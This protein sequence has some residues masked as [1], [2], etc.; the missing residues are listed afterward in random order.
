MT[1]QLL[2]KQ[3]IEYVTRNA[4]DNEDVRQFK[5]RLQEAIF[6]AEHTGVE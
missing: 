4:P 2:K 1:L 3:L 5:L 6:W